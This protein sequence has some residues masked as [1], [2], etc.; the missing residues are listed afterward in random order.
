M[1]WGLMI[2]ENQLQECVQSLAR[3]KSKNVTLAASSE[4]D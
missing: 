3:V 4:I 1:S 2:A